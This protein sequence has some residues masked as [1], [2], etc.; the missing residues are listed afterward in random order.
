MVIH[1]CESSKEDIREG[2]QHVAYG[3]LGECTKSLGLWS[4]SDGVWRSVNV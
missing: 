3:T 1:K 4:I 2:V